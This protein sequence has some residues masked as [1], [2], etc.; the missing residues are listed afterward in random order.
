[1]PYNLACILI[2]SGISERLRYR[3]WYKIA[4]FKFKIYNNF[5]L[6]HNSKKPNRERNVYEII[7]TRTLL[8]AKFISKNIKLK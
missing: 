6:P 5:R 1:M 2:S 8:K 7:L 4:P 3:Q